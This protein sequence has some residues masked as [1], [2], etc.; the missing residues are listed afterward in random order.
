MD[1]Y[2]KELKDLKELAKS[3]SVEDSQICWE[4]FPSKR[5]AQYNEC[6]MNAVI[7]Y[8]VFCEGKRDIKALK[9]QKLSSCGQ[10]FN[11]KEIFICKNTVY[12]DIIP[13]IHS[14]H[15]WMEKERKK[16]LSTLE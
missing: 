4:K 1:T 10:I 11:P 16:F 15:L 12:Q 9:K 7:S 13:H 3:W 5:K 2:K 14:L 8:H 6:S